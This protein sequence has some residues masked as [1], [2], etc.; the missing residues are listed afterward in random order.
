MG[1]PI[2]IAST[3]K[4]KEKRLLTGEVETAD[5]EDIG[6]LGESPDLGLLQV[7]EVIVVGS[8]K[9]GAERPV[10]AGDDGAAPAGRGLGVDAV[11]DPQA[12]GL[13]GIT[14]D[15]GIL[16]IADAAEVDDAV[17]GEDVLGS[18]G[19]VLGSAAGEELG[20]VVVQEVLVDGEVLILGEDSVVGLEAVLLKKSIVAE[21]LDVCLKGGRRVSAYSTT[22][23]DVSTSF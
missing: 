20:V 3:L 14:E 15:S 16:I 9:G 19:G 5:V 12:N 11:L 17:G 8:V 1:A 10:V 2:S 21:G 13:N 4:R 7:V 6:V 18:A 22:T 23:L